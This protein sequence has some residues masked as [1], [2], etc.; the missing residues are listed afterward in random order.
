[1]RRPSWP[2]AVGGALIALLVLFSWLVPA[3]SPH[4]PYES[5]FVGGIGADDLP[6]GPTWRFPLGVDLVYRD[7]LT[8]LALAGRASLLIGVGATAIAVVLG[9]LVGVV[10]GYFEGREEAR[11]PLVAIATAA[12]GAWTTS[13]WPALAAAVFVAALLSAAALARRSGVR[14]A[15]FGPHIDSVL[16]RFVDAALAFPF[17]LLILAVG[18][19]VDVTTPATVLV[20]LGLTSWLGVARVV[21]AKALQLRS[22]AYVEAAR[23][24]G[25]SDGRILVAHVLPNVLTPVRALAVVLVAQMILAESVLG[26]LGAGTPPP[27]PTWGHMLAEGQEAMASAPWLLAAPA[28]ALIVAVLG[29]NLLGEG[30]RRALERSKR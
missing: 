13:R 24:L 20:T 6:V 17:L 7:V 12:V 11:V 26:Y 3:L 25:Q 28:S 14:A 1:M 19:A 8:R 21:R 9:T 22:A 27:V 30:L 29:F 2:V 10:A 23:A 16:M 15:A 4:D 18:S 5:D